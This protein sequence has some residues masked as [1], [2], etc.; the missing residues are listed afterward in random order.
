MTVEKRTKKVVRQANIM[1]TLRL[2]DKTE[3]FAVLATADTEGPYASLVAY[4][5]D[6]SG[7]KIVLATPRNSR[8]YRNLL[9]QKHVAL[10]IDRRSRPGESIMKGEAV[11][12]VGKA[13]PVRRGS[14]WE[15]TAACFLN[16][17]PYLADFI[18]ERSTALVMVELSE[19]VHVG[20]F[21]EVSSWKIDA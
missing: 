19:A 1:R 9:K 5:L 18:H 12:L 2:F 15:S 13:V 3:P 16:K 10:L 8:K 4:A 17:H 21:Q 20:R 14:R 7:S 11:T 6:E